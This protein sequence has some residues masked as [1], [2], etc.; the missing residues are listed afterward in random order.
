M[1][2]GTR[3]LLEN[4]GVVT[5]YAKFGTNRWNSYIDMSNT[6]KNKSE[7]KISNGFE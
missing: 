7:L 4:I 2:N 5:S 6:Y 1:V 3:T